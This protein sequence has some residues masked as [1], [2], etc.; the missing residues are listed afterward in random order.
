MSEK[1]AL[2]KQLRYKAVELA[3]ADGGTAGVMMCYLPSPS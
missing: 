2:V 1:S 3:V